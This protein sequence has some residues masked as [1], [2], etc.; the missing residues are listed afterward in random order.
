MNQRQ[1]VLEHL[2]RR[3]AITSLEAFYNYKITRL[4]A[5][6]FD[7]R[8][9]GHN[10]VTINKTRADRDGKTVSRWAEYRLVQ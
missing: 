6:I 5:V 10:I 3:G 4:A 2:K 7:L 1:I 8:A 9:A